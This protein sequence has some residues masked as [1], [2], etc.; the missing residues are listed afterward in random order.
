MLFWVCPGVHWRELP[1]RFNLGAGIS[2]VFLHAGS[3]SF[4]FWWTKGKE[5]IFT[6]Q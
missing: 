4:P 5:K 3:S 1:D 6:E 2:A